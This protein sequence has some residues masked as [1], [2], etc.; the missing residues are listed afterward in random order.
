[1]SK[2]ETKILPRVSHVTVPLIANGHFKRNVPLPIFSMIV[3]SMDVEVRKTT[4]QFLLVAAVLLS[5]I[6]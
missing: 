5:G 3:A 4:S 2:S 6:A 1:M